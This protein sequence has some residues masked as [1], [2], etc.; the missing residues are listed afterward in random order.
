MFK[1][2]KCLPSL[3]HNKTSR[4]ERLILFTELISEMDPLCGPVTSLSFF[5]ML[6]QVNAKRLPQATT[7]LSSVVIPPGI[8]PGL[9]G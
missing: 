8:E 3:D 7:E 2:F 5:V 6:S 9:P 4:L 1:F